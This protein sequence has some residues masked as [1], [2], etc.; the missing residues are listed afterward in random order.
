MKELLLVVIVVVLAI[1]ISGLINTS[2]P[3]QMVAL[4]P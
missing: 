1:E 4:S 2:P 3:P